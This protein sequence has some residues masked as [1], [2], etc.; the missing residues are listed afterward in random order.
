MLDGSFKA[1]TA[2][3]SDA[4]YQQAQ[5]I[6]AQDMPIMPWGYYK[7]SYIWNPTVTNVTRVGPFDEIALEKV[8]VANA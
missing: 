2:S 6:V 8:Q 1:R 3:A 4:L 7:Y 5:Q